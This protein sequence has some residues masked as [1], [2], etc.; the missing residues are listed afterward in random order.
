MGVSLTEW[1]LNFG[2]G[3]VFIFLVATGV[4]V[5]GFIYKDRERVIEK[6]TDALE[7]ERQRNADLQQLAA[8]GAK[9]LDALAQVAHENRALQAVSVPPPGKEGT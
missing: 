4:F 7:V 3:G 9:A 2:L 1:L 8:T 6:L 5:P